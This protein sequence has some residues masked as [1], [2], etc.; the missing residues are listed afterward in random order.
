MIKAYFKEPEKKESNKE[1][2]GLSEPSVSEVKAPEEKEKRWMTKEQQEKIAELIEKMIHAEGAEEVG[3]IRDEIAKI[4]SGE[5]KKS[6]KVK[7]FKVT[8]FY[9]VVKKDA[10]WAGCNESGGS[11]RFYTFKPGEVITEITEYDKERALLKF[12]AIK[13]GIKR[14]FNF[15]WTSIHLLNNFFIF[16]NEPKSGKFPE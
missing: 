1:V 5:G 9:V 12:N 3:R 4:E 13:A 8:D 6:K 14:T 10:K 16:N 7:E 2:G 11:L 15:R